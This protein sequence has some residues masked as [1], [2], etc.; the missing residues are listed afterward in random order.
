MKCEFFIKRQQ[1]LQVVPLPMSSADS[2]V[3]TVTNLC[4]FVPPAKAQPK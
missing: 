2:P 4:Q 3:A 1:F